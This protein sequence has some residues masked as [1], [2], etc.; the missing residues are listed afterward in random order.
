MTVTMSLSLSSLFIDYFPL[1]DFSFIPI[2]LYSSFD[3]HLFYNL[4]TP[5]FFPIYLILISVSIPRF[6][7][8]LSLCSAL[9][10]L[11][12]SSLSPLNI[13]F[14][15]STR[16]SMSPQLSYFFSSSPSPLTP[17]HSLSSHSLSS[18][19]TP[20]LSLPGDSL[21]L[22]LGTI[23]HVSYPSLSLWIP[24]HLC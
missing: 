9:F 15:L 7:S 4:I 22:P 19:S 1:S 17:L 3:T 18:H 11:L 12:L 24:D 6:F 21:L 5:Y 2:H 13:H 16:P 23:C 10:T 14:F 8:S 20:S